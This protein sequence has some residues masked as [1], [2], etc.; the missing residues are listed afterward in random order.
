MRIEKI[1]LTEIRLPLRERFEISSGWTE[2]RRIPLLTVHAEGEVGWGELV[3]GDAPSYS[4]ETTDTAWHILTRTIIPAILGTDPDAAADVLAPVT[5]IRGHRMAKA[6]VEMAAWDLEAK[7]KGVS[8]RTLLG[9]VREAVE[10][11]VSIG[12]QPTHDAVLR[13]VEGYLGQGYRKIKVKI[14]PGRDIEVLRAIRD[15]FPEI[16]LMADAN[17]AYRLSDASRLAELDDLDLMMI[18]QPL[19]HDDYLDHA[20]LQSRLR[21]PICLDESIRSVDDVRLALHLDSGRVINIKPGRVGGLG[22]SADIEA[23]CRSRDVPVWC[24]GM[25]E[26][27]VG[28]AHNLAL[29][30]L[31]GFTR[32]GDISESR[33][34]FQRDIVTP[35]FVMNEGMMA[36]PEGPGIGVEPDVERIEALAVRKEAFAA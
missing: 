33:R 36:V 31:A 2:M 8:L 11:G 28:R 21:T 15:R 9:G 16:P 4:S 20:T 12:I 10:V 29:A 3:A 32:P 23:L 13:R 35:E 22:S 27:G 1:E 5:W 34:Y 17:S 14:K 25:L 30:S 7:L 24:G 19:A 26:A 6:A 18:E